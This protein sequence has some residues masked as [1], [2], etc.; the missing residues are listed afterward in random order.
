MKKA[1]PEK[2]RKEIEEKQGWGSAENWSNYDFEKLSEEILQATE[3]SLSVST[4]KRFFGK[5]KS[6]SKPSFTTMNVLASYIGYEDWRNF[7]NSALKNE[8]IIAEHP[9]QA[10]KERRGEKIVIKPYLY[11]SL[12]V[13][14]A[15]G[16][17]LYLKAT[18]K[19][20]PEDFSFSS[21]T[22][23][24]KGLPNSVVFDY[25]ASKVKDSDSVFISQNWDV[26]RKT[27]VNKNDKHHSSIYYYPGYFRA[28]LMAG[29]YVL[30]EHDI[31]IITD[32]W[33]GIL[34][35]P[36]NQRPLYFAKEKIYHDTYI[37]LSKK[38]LE[39]Y[40]VDLGP[41][42]P[43]VWFSNQKDLANFKTDNFEFEIE[44]K[45]DYSE[46]KAACQ[47]V[48]VLLQAKDDILIVPLS[49]PACVGDLFLSA[50][51]FGVNS[52][53]ADLSGFGANLSDWVNLKVLCK[54][55]KL[56]FYVNDKLAYKAEIKN[57]VNEIVGVHVRF[58]GPGS[59]RNAV[60]KS[61]KKVCNFD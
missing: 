2:L 15:A 61:G 6:T 49:Q 5:V 56:K 54:D 38:S 10:P 21:K 35:G 22:I 33:T 14:L 17:F 28:K 32:D 25:D 44:V 31:Q 53:S 9:I 20:N 57:A 29:N 4:L 52:S 37:G 58:E 55:K 41:E 39:E 40:N 16:I 50:Y 59:L 26:S 24:S 60:L 47:K 12:L 27:L 34:A 30:K 51:G 36:R 43:Q 46:G 1:T 8:E 3:V 18:P 11:S 7:E 42:L 13:V 48:Q 23:L 45:S 19:Y